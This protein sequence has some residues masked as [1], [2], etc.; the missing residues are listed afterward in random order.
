VGS[1]SRSRFCLLLAT[2]AGL[3][4]SCTHP[5]TKTPAVP[6]ASQPVAKITPVP[7]P[8]EVPVYCIEG[9]EPKSI[10]E[11]NKRYII[12]AARDRE[13][14]RQIWLIANGSSWGERFQLYFLPDRVSGRARLGKG[15]AFSY[16]DFT[17]ARAGRPLQELKIEPF[18]YVQVGDEVPEK[19]VPRPQNM[20]FEMPD[21]LALAEVDEIVTRI[22]LNEKLVDDEG[23]EMEV[24]HSYP[25]N[26]LGREGDSVE[27]MSG[28]IRG[29]LNGGGQSI[30]FKKVMG[31][32]VVKGFSSW[33]S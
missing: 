12:E 27:V 7:L 21:G 23:F 6:S 19:F 14:S 13:P 22:Q 17:E 29:P 2:V 32:W 1:F 9:R 28:F 16:R 26:G 20:P 15:L 24:D 3:A 25:I 11:N 31:K 4:S 10:D 18:D 33:V 30:K 8:A 5:L